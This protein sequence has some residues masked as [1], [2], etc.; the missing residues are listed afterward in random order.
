MLHFAARGE[1]R[2]SA[3]AAPQRAGRM[4]RR[5]RRACLAAA[6]LLV[7]CAWR[8]CLAAE[9]ETVKGL[10]AAEEAQAK[11]VAPGAPVISDVIEQAGPA[12]LARCALARML[13][14]AC[15][16]LL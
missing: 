15:S 14:R 7:A 2:A 12:V 6:L 10:A 5:A 13:V 3:A 11:G 4:A 1:R 8:P 9:T 16:R